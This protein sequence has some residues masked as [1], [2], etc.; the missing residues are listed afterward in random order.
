MKQTH[1]RRDIQIFLP[2]ISLA[3]SICFPGTASEP[4]HPCN[5][6]RSITVQVISSNGLLGSGVLTRKEGETYTVVTSAHVING[7]TLTIRTS[8]RREHDANLVRRYDTESSI[9]N[10]VAEVSFESD[11]NYDVA[12]FASS[13]RVGERIHVAGF[14]DNSPEAENFTCLTSDVSFVLDQPMEQGYQLGYL[15]AVQNGTSGGPVL[16]QEGYVVGINGLSVPVIFQNPQL[17][18]YRDGSLVPYPLNQLAGSS[19]AILTDEFSNETVSS[20]PEPNRTLEEPTREPIPEEENRSVISRDLPEMIC[21][22]NSAV[23]PSQASL[24]RENIPSCLYEIARQ[25]T[26]QVVVRSPTRQNNY[27]LVGSAVIYQKIENHYFVLVNSQLLELREQQDSFLIKAP[28][29]FSN[30]SE[31]IYYSLTLVKTLPERGL[32]IL[33]FTSEKDYPI[34]ERQHSTTSETRNNAYLFGWGREGEEPSFEFSSID[35]RSRG[36]YLALDYDSQDLRL[37]GGGIILDR[38]GN[39]IGIQTD[40]N[41]GVLVNEEVEVLYPFSVDRFRVD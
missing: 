33:M 38:Q 15:T 25:G 26:I 7:D 23:T 31:N 37:L 9:E 39:L 4:F 27:V 10:D 22:E 32:A 6:A 3:T 13:P 36:R 35:V 17:Y 40:I 28:D 24:G 2:I 5:I 30:G 29:N 34:V 21:E 12:E 14:V 8:D 19:W 16:N 20:N 11:S 1:M 41:K 18:R